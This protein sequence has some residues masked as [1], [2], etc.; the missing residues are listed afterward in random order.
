[1]RSAQYTAGTTAIKIADQTGSSRKLS[2]HVETSATY[3]GDRGVTSTTG[4]K[5]DANDKITLDLAGGAELWAVTASGSAP[6]YIL[7]I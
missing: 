6:V 4:Y 1:M 3:L 2:I 7:E 5:M